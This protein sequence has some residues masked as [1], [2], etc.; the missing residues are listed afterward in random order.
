MIITIGGLLLFSWLFIRSRGVTIVGL[1]LG[2][3]IFVGTEVAVRWV[4]DSKCWFVH[5]K[6]TILKWK[7]FKR[8]DDN[9]TVGMIW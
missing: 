2:S 8:N 7:T 4:S 9:D 5:L 3:L 1:L 6:K